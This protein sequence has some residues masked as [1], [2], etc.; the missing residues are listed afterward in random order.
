MSPSEID[1]QR[2]F[3]DDLF[4]DD[5]GEQM[6]ILSHEWASIKLIFDNADKDELM[7][8]FGDDFVPN[9]DDWMIEST[10]K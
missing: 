10:E 5:F 6:I 4:L 1:F 3:G 7:K 9:I 8:Q 2:Y